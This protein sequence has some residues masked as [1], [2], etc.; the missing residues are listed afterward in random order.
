[1]FAFMTGIQR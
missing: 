1:M